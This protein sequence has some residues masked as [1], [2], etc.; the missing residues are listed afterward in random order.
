M[1][2]V[3][4]RDRQK[5]S[6]ACRPILGKYTDGIGGR[7]IDLPAVF[8]LL[9]GTTT[10][11]SL[12]TPLMAGIINELVP[13]ERNRTVVTIVILIVTCVTYTYSLLHGFKGISLLAKTCIYLFFGLLVYVFLFSG[14]SGLYCRDWFL[15]PWKNDTEFSGTCHFYR[16]ST[17]YVVSTELDDL[18]LGVLD[19]VV[20]GS[21]VLYRK[22]LKGTYHP[23]D[24]P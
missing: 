2:H 22:Y 4:R 9:A 24:D 1:L 13:V 18:L 5:Y 14:K 15:R 16:S 6:E 23:P 10:T 11:F 8:A 3:R 19:G 12:A 21:A 20:C 17:D 7:L